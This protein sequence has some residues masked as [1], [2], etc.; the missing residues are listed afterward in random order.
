MSFQRHRSP[1]P[2]AHCA[3]E[4]RRTPFGLAPCGVE[5][6]PSTDAIAVRLLLRATVFF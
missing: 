4:S 5:K 1:E 3:G 6:R 2:P